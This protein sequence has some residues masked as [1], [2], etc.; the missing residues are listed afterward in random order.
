LFSKPCPAAQGWRRGRA[1]IKYGKRAKVALG[2]LDHRQRFAV[3]FSG[4]VANDI[5]VTTRPAVARRHDPFDRKAVTSRAF[6]RLAAREIASGH[7]TDERFSPVNVSARGG[8][9]RSLTRFGQFDQPESGPSLS[10]ASGISEGSGPVL[11]SITNGSAIAC[12]S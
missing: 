3:N 8:S 1:A 2:Q 11:P 12:G 7:E 6:G 10:L 5:P 4:F 9:D